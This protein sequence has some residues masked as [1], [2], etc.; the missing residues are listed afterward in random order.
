MELQHWLLHS[1][2]VTLS[3]T[4][5]GRAL[6]Y[7]CFGLGDEAFDQYRGFLKAPVSSFMHNPNYRYNTHNPTQSNPAEG[8]HRKICHEISNHEKMH[9]IVRY[10]WRDDELNDHNCKLAM[11]A[12][13]IIGAM[14]E[15]ENCIYDEL[16][17]YIWKERHFTQ[18]R[19]LFHSDDG[20][21][22]DMEI[23]GKRSNHERL[24]ALH[25]SIRNASV[26]ALQECG[27]DVYGTID[28]EEHVFSIDDLFANE[29]PL[30]AEHKLW[31]SKQWR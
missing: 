23:I 27:C 29:T 28:D 6:F 30:F 24:I 22:D 7:R 21:A 11:S 17:V 8:G 25:A 19:F 3:G 5:S 1:Q 16:K 26:K 20:W 9:D 2:S 13:E 10:D 18:V 12:V 4:V 31:V 15:A 14:I